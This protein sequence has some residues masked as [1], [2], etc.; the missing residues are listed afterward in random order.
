MWTTLNE[1]SSG[2]VEGLNNKA[3]VTILLLPRICV[4]RD[5]LA[6]GYRDRRKHILVA[7]EGCVMRNAYGYR[8]YET[9]EASLFHTMGNLPEPEFSHKFW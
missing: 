2:I 4:V 9:L 7:A 3:K 1:I 5:N 6:S 8:S